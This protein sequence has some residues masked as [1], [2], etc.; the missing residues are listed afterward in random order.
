M[1]DYVDV[2]WRLYEDVDASNDDYFF[3]FFVRRSRFGQQSQTQCVYSQMLQGR[4]LIK[5]KIEQTRKEKES[6]VK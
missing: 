3:F 1:E 6:K 5:Q 2:V 4:K